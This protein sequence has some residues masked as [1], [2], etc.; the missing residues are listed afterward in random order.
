MIKCRPLV[1]AVLT[2]ILALGAGMIGYLSLG[3][4]GLAFVFLMLTCVL[5]S[6]AYR[7]WEEADE[8]LPL[9][10]RGAESESLRPIQE[11]ST[12]LTAAE[13]MATALKK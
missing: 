13:P 5:V 12:A 6:A 4:P 7:G 8:N 9:S 2:F 10:A 11:Q 3:L 1:Y